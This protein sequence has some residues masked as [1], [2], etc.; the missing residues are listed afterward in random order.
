MAEIRDRLEKIE[1]LCHEDPVPRNLTKAE[2]RE[3]RKISP[4]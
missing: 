1:E 3:V 4:W 2:C